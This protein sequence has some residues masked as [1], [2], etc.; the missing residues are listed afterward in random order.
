MLFHSK[1]GTLGSSA[2][3]GPSQDLR[4]AAKAFQKEADPSNGGVVN[5]FPTLLP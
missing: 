5:H 2:F 1:R 3:K 4:K